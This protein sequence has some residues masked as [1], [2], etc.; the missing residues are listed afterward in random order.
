GGG[1]RQVGVLASAGLIA[2]EKMTARLVEDHANAK[3]LAEGLAATPGV[4][5]NPESVQTNIVIFDIGKSGTNTKDLS[6]RLKERG[7]L[8]NGINPRE[9]RMCTHY[10]VTREDCETALAILREILTERL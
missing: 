6:A 1:M 3:L 2:L 9:M 4:S 10:D 7:V 8:A 5:I